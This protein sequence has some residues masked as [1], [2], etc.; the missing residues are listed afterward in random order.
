[1]NRIEKPI[2]PRKT[3]KEL[4]DKVKRIRDDNVEVVKLWTKL[5]NKACGMN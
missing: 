4:A 5:N 3:I 2:K 1:M